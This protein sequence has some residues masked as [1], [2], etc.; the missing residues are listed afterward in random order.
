MRY[1]LLV[2]CA[3]AACAQTTLLDRMT[4]DAPRYAALSRQIWGFAEIGYK[5]ERSAALLSGELEKAGFR[6]QRGV[7][8]MPTAFT[9]EWGKGTPVIALLG[10]YDAL[11]GLS[12]EAVPERKAV[13]EGGAGHGCGHNTFGVAVAHA[14][15]A[16][17]QAMEQGKLSGTI[18]YYGTPAEEGGGG[19]IH[20]I[21][22]GLFKDVDAA[23]TWHP[24]DQNAAT[25]QTWLA[26]VSGRF[27]FRGKASHAAAAP[28]AGRSASDAVMVM[29]HAVDLMREHV[30]QETR[31]HYMIER[32][33]S[34][35]N[36]VPETGELVLMARHS[37]AGVLAGIW[38]RL[39]NC[40]QA[41]ALATGTAMDFQITGS[42]A[43]TVANRTLSGLLDR[44]MR[45]VGGYK[46]TADE[47]KFA[48]G[49]R[50]TL[51]NS[52]ASADA[53]EKIQGP[54]NGVFSGSTDVGDVSW[55]VPTAQFLA[56]TW[57]P[58]TAAH[59]WQSTAAS[60][61]TIGDK[62]L[63]VAARTLALATVELLQN[64]ELVKA[65]R[66]EFDKNLAGREYK[67]L[68][69]KEVRPR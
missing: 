18:R 21:R 17:K 58:G 13:V 65:A 4:A 44:S 40:A 29:T 23:L 12:Q 52:T 32:A 50:P 42:Y 66:A 38:E 56:A 11:P 2:L 63:A 46:Y 69:P 61:T 28:E 45:K 26:T 43:N 16:V 39:L 53:H 27:R 48:E 19:K 9:A 37:D 22:A 20:M 31:I 51:S 3:S 8:A 54:L 67:S 14:A 24:W 47:A 36:I 55:V 7:A 62:G 15:I 68:H 49:I 60:G 64:P 5:E 30:P 41:G 57:V 59:T 1:C 6:V 10:E 35:V 33:G 34:A 25:D